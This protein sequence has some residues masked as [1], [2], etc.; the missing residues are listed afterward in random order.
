MRACLSGMTSDGYIHLPALLTHMKHKPT[1]QDIR[2]TVSCDVK[3]HAFGICKPSFFLLSLTAHTACFHTSA[4]YFA[5]PFVY[6]ST[7]CL[8]CPDFYQQQLWQLSAYNALH[9]YLAWPELLSAYMFEHSN[10]LT[11][12][13]E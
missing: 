13:A 3:V 8:A 9:T 1:E 7:R 2:A 11:Y 12:S 10:W 5:G 6:T 4:C